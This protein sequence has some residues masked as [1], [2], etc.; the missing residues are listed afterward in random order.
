MRARKRTQKVLEERDRPPAASM[1]TQLRQ[2]K[3]REHGPTGLRA[4][5]RIL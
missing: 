3:T 2:K 4:K 1:T 5:K